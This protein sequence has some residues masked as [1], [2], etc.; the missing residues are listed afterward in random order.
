LRKE[1]WK[2]GEQPHKIWRSRGEGSLL[3]DSRKH[4]R[5]RT[6]HVW[7]ERRP[8]T[9]KRQRK[10]KCGGFITEKRGDISKKL[11]SG[12]GGGTWGQGTPEEGK[13]RNAKFS[14]EKKAFLL[15]HLKELAGKKKI[16]RRKYKTTNKRGL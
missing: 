7:E 9:K 13:D 3:P 11:E 16:L 8:G 1:V 5:K 2:K 4:Q 12:E 15:P 6:D 10:K 14:N